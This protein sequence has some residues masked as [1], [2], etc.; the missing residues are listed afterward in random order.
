[1]FWSRGMAYISHSVTH[2]Y[3]ILTTLCWFP[4]LGAYR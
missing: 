1:M 2:P 3:V 4:T